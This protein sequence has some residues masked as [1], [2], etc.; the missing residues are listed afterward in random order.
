MTFSFSP[1]DK[2][3]ISP[4]TVYQRY[5]RYLEVAD[6]SH[7]EKGQGPRLHDIRHTFAVHV[8]QKWIKEEADLTAML[9]ILSTY[10]GHKSR[11]VPVMKPIGELLKQYMEGSG[12]TSPVYGRNPL[13]TNAV[14]YWG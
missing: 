11:I 12:L 2:T 5:R 1:P 9:P 6:I 14:S 3:M 10:M 4:M 7:G 8:L 13:F